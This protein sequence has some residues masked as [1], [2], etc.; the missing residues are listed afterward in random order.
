MKYFIAFIL[1]T[2]C[3]VSCGSYSGCNYK[4]AKLVSKNFSREYTGLDTL[5]RLDGY[6]YR[7]ETEES[8]YPFV[9]SKNGEVEV[10]YFILKTHEEIQHYITRSKPFYGSY[11]IKGDTINIKWSEKY[12]F[13]SYL[14]FSEDYVIVNDTT[15]RQVRRSGKVCVEDKKFEK[16]TNVVYHLYRIT[17]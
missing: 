5:I 9:L 1:I 7:G 13:G 2:I 4:E 17:K 11:T 10:F 14:I 3:Y 6:Y 15:L 8:L 16:A 12:D